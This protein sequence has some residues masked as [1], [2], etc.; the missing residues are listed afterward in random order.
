MP[1]GD[2]QQQAVTDAGVVIEQE[3]RR[4]RTSRLDGS[5]LDQAAWMGVM[6]A[7]QRYDESRG[8]FTAYARL[9][10][11]KELQR[12]VGNGEFVAGLPSDYPRRAVL[13]RQI[14]AEAGT[15][16]AAGDRLGLPADA[17]GPL[18]AIVEA[19][20]LDDLTTERPIGSLASA[21][22]ELEDEVIARVEADAVARAVAGL[23]HRLRI[24]V[25]LAYGLDGGGERSA[26][27]IAR[28]VG[29]SDFTVRSDLDRARVLL[30]AALDGLRSDGTSP[31]TVL[32]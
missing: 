29:V 23:E 8:P 12:A 5:D 19:Q 15:E 3:V 2:A 27:E 9:W 13:I 24:A 31:L 22:D 11:R 20:S 6:E 1:D 21:A 10:V 4:Y 18:L 30:R 28:A 7:S 16:A 32:V 14:I 25:T 26:R 17:V